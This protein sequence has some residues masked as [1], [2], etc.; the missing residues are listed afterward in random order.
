MSDCIG[1]QFV[2]IAKAKQAL[3][4]STNIDTSPNEMACLDSFLFRCWQMGWLDKYD[5]SKDFVEVVRCKDCKWWTILPPDKQFID[6]RVYGTCYKWSAMAQDGICTQKH[7]Y[8][9]YGEREDNGE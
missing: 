8:C 3:L 5:D 1:N 2:I 6:G 7:Y 4:D 9:N